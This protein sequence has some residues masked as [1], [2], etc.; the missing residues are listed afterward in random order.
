MPTPQSMTHLICHRSLQVVN[1]IVALRCLSHACTVRQ[2]THKE[3]KLH[4]SIERC[5]E[6][7][8]TV[9]QFVQAKVTRM[10]SLPGMKQSKSGHHNVET[11]QLLL[12]HLTMDLRSG[13]VKGNTLGRVRVERESVG[14]L[15]LTI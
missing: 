7:K 8:H 3:R 9:N 6:K 15:R 13:K 12:A 2:S 11:H 10:T 1:T 14:M 4:G 5:K